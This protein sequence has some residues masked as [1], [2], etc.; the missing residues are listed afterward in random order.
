MKEQIEKLDELQKA[1]NN[2]R[3]I[4][5]IRDIIAVINYGMTDAAARIAI[6]DNDKIRNYPEVQKH[7]RTMLPAYDEQLKSFENMWLPD[8]SE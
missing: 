7:L 5:V 6:H 1:C 2:G 4:Q 3:G 8:E